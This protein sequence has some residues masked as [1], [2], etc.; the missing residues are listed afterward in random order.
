MNETNDLFKYSE[1]DI[2]LEKV[3]R[4]VRSDIEI[5]T[6]VLRNVIIEFVNERIRK[7]NLDDRSRHLEF[8]LL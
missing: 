3:N 8:L 6:D 5:Y 4:F 2:R 7:S 1:I